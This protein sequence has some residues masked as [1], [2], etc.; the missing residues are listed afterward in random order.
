MTIEEIKARIA[1]IDALLDDD[2]TT[3]AEFDALEEEARRL[4]QEL[5]CMEQAAQLRNVRT[6]SN[7]ND[8]TRDFLASFGNRSLTRKISLNQARVFVRLNNSKPFIYN[9]LRYDCSGMDYRA[10]FSSLI[11]TKI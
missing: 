10:G 2:A 3:D 7:V 8:W 1:A 9:G 4:T 5:G 11:I 6:L